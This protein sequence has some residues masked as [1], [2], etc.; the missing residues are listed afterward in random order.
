M[1]SVLMLWQ[2][3]LAYEMCSCIMKSTLVMKSVLVLWQVNLVYE[4]SAC[5]MTATLGF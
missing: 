4:I 3:N 1:K 5:V 2:V